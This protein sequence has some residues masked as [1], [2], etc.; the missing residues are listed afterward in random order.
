MTTLIKPS[1]LQKS[2]SKFMPKKFYEIDPRSTFVEEASKAQ[3]RPLKAAKDFRSLS[4]DSQDDDKLRWLLAK[5]PVIL[6][7]GRTSFGW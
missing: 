4:V 6:T 2:V 3:Q 5:C 1:S 7:N